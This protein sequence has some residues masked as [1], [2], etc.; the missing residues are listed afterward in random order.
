MTLA[1]VKLYL[2]VDGNDE[3]TEIQTMI[4]A[5]SKEIQRRSGKT[6]VVVEAVETDIAT[7]ELFQMAVKIGV[8]DIYTNRGSEA[9]GTAK[10]TQFSRTFTGM[11]QF[12]AVC[13]DYV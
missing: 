6:K 5:V 7:D 3:D 9:V 8:A 11:T 1:D 13:G 12:I 10:V 4:T 2:R